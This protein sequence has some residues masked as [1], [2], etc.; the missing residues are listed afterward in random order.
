MLGSMRTALLA[1]VVCGLAGPRVAADSVHVQGFNDSSVSPWVETTYDNDDQP[2]VDWST[3][4]SSDCPSLNAAYEGSRMARFNSCYADSGDEARLRSPDLDLTGAEVAEVRFWMYHDPG[5]SGSDDRLRLQVS[6]DGGETYATKLDLG[7]YA[8]GAGWREEVVAL[9]YYT[10]L[11]NLRLALRGE[12]RGGQ[13]IYVDDVRVTKDVLPAGAEGK[14][15]AA[16]GDCDSGLCGVDPFGQGRCRAAA[17][18]CIGAHREPV[19]AGQTVCAGPD[20]ATCNGPDD[21]TR[22]DC[23]DDCGAYLDVHECEHTGAGFQCIECVEDCVYLFGISE[24]CDEDA[25]C[26]FYLIGGD[27]IRK[28]DTGGACDENRQCLSNNCVPSPG[29]QKYC[30]PAGTHCADGAGQPVADGETICFGGDRYECQAVGW[31]YTDCY[32][33]CGFYDDVDDCLDGACVDCPTS[34]VNDADCK[35]DIQCIDNECVGGLPLGATCQQDQQCDSGHCIDGRCCADI[36]SALCHRCDIDASG[37]CKPIPQ[38]QD[39]DGECPGQGA[40]DGTCNGQGACGYP[41][42]ATC[43]VCARC[44]AQGRCMTFVAAGTDPADECPACQVCHGSQPG[45][46]AVA[47][48]ADPLDDCAETPAT[49]CGLDG[50]CDGEGACRNWP[51]GTVCAPSSCSGGVEQQ[52]DTCDGAGRCVA[53]QTIDCAPYRCADEDACA[54][55]CQSHAE[56]I[57][58]AF[59]NTQGACAAD[60]VD[61]SDCRDVVYGGLL[62]DAACAG[63]FCFEDDFDG[64]GA[65][66]TANAT[67]CVHDGQSFPA[68]YALCG[69]GDWYK[70]CVGGVPGWGEEIGC[71]AGACDAGDGP[72]S[73]V[74]AGGSC[75]SGPNGGCSTECISCAPYRAAADGSACRESCA[76]DGDC[77]SGYVCRDG[78]CRLPEGIGDSCASQADCSAGVC[79]DGRCCESSCTGACRACNL[80]GREGLCTAVEAGTDPDEDCPAQQAETCGTTGV[81][82]GEGACQFWPADQVCAAPGCE[83]GVFLDEAYCDGAGHCLPAGQTDCSPGRCT[84]QGCVED[85]ASHADCAAAGFCAVDGVCLLDLA[86][87][88]SC[89]GVVLAGLES[90]PACAG[91]YCLLDGWAGEGAW[92]ASAID[93]CTAAGAVYEPGYRLCSQDGWFRVCLG[94][95]A[96]WGP[97]VA[98]APAGVCD[99]G[100]G[101][102]SGVTDAEVCDSGPQGGCWAACRSCYP[103]RAVA[104]GQCAASCGEEADCWPGHVCSGGACEPD[105]VLGNDCQSDADCDGHVCVDGVCCNLACDGTCLLCDDPI[106][107]GV[108]LPAAAGTDPNDECPDEPDCGGTGH[109]DGQAA[110]ALQPAGTVC[111]P[112]R[113][114]DGVRLSVGLCDGQGACEAGLEHPCP[115]GACAGDRCA[116]VAVDGGGD[117]DGGLPDGGDGPDE[118]LRAE[119][120]PRQVVAP[121]SQVVLDGS[122]STGPA[123]VELVYLWE[124]TSGPEQV[125]LT[126]AAT[127]RAGFVAGASGVY[128][129]RLVVA[130]GQQQ[131]DPDF[132]QVQVTGGAGGCGCSAGGSDAGWL[133]LV[134]VALLA[135]GRRWRAG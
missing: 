4:P 77:W 20:V 85:C 57:P 1:L 97:E 14:A 70:V 59:C 90:D 76:E 58:Q 38:G 54:T 26:D 116:P 61:G 131:S 71:A 104:P 98:C 35:P 50:W 34:C 84:A 122:A 123:G 9:G 11:A 19:A 15:C 73:G 133:G 69:D 134:L 8:A 32:T 79:V 67:G 42:G 117:A 99:A 52:A 30:V 55:A 89:D 107:R 129:F 45:C 108:C 127:P 110:C 5:L 29:G 119:A 27:C 93:A 105:A 2:D 126:G 16:A 109:C 53:G 62:D 21:W 3:V 46:V 31:A 74:R 44:D 47:A 101:P 65:F 60:L 106:A 87:G 33:N 72:G 39:P 91:G 130:A 95:E 6:A 100:G 36:C 82:D 23:F 41:V 83:G 10:G 17:T 128:G 24:G 56:C 96:G 64:Q 7:R 63:G 132:T 51:A 37:Q 102:G 114:E 111:Q 43:D 81:C 121:G 86:D 49:G 124:Q 115:S 22:V 48:G 25:Y 78:Q 12:C 94:G 112:A 135:M 75:V 118:R 120:G 40:C 18:D 88:Q 66:C 13:N 80:P 92:C 103:Y 125:E 113:C 68:G 28:L